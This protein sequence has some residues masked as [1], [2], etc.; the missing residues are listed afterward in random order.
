MKAIKLTKA[1]QLELQTGWR[2]R[3]VRL[4]EMGLPKDTFEQYVDWVH[5]RGI[6]TKPGTALNSP[7][8]GFTSRYVTSAPAPAA[9]NDARHWVKGATWSKPAPTYTGTAMLGIGVMHKSNAV[10]VFSTDEAKSLGAMR[11]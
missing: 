3:N 6:K 10:P 11:R 5:G 1:R 9:I 2:E 7:V 4:R 8:V